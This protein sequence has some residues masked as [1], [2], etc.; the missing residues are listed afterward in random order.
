[1]TSV[2]QKFI[3]LKF[4]GCGHLL[5]YHLGVSSVF[6]EHESKLYYN[7]KSGKKRSIPRIKSVSGSSSGAIAAVCYARLP[8]RVEEF[9]ERFIS[10]RGHALQTLQTMLHQEENSLNMDNGPST[11]PI[12]AKGKYEAPPSLHIATTKCVDGSHYLFH[13]SGC[14]NQYSSISSAW[15][16][17]KILDAVKASC[18]IPQSFH[19]ADI[20]FKSQNISY[21]VHEGIIIDGEGHVDGGIAAPA[22][23]TPYDN[24]AGACPINVSPI[25][26]GES[27]IFPLKQKKEMRISPKDYSWRLLPISNLNCRGDFDVKPSLQNL[28]ALSMASGLVSSIELQDWYDR[29]IDDALRILDDYHDD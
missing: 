24:V 5:P 1:M 27:F 17:D 8:H 4:S 13:F 15:T 29:G 25:S 6:L 23:R 26:V 2:S 14:V 9:A 20:I 28:R 16:T 22:P 10:D 12:I 18:T 19:P 3:T 11:S 7:G 21:S